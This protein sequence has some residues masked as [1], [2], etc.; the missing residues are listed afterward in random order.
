[1]SSERSWC[2]RQ[3]K[4]AGSITIF[5]ITFFITTMR[6]DGEYLGSSTADQLV[7][8]MF[9]DPQ[10]DLQMTAVFTKHYVIQQTLEEE[11]RAADMEHIANIEKARHNVI[12]YAWSKVYHPFLLLFN[13]FK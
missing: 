4:T 2:H 3:G 7:M 9:A 6:N 10:H 1:M 13:S 12:V 11:R 5:T 8:D